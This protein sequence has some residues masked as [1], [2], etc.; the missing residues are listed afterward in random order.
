MFRNLLK[1]KQPAVE[2]IDD[3]LDD[4]QRDRMRNLFATPDWHNIGRPVLQTYISE[5]MNTTKVP[6]VNNVKDW[7]ELAYQ[8]NEAAKMAMK[9]LNLFDAWAKEPP[10]VS[11][12]DSMR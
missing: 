8:R 1:E 6:Q 10:K 2:D 7:G 9:L 5:L 4:T 11:P 12:K 3:R